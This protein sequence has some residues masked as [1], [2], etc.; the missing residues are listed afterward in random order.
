MQAITKVFSDI[1]KPYIDATDNGL[2]DNDFTN[3][4]VNLLPLITYTNRQFGDATNGYITV[5]SN[6]DGSFTLNGSR[7]STASVLLIPIIKDG[8]Y[9][10]TNN[11]LKKGKS[12]KYSCCPP[13]SVS[14]HL[15]SQI[16]Y[17][18]GS[19]NLVQ[20]EEG[21][22]G[23]T[24]NIPIDATAGNCNIAVYHDADFTDVIISKIQ[25]FLCFT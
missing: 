2:I 3:G 23:V 20:F 15:L 4:A 13:N 11:I 12:Y 17:R 9:L 5:N 19:N 16:N 14:Q 22:A 25:I 21:G 1:V 18:D 8:K 7:I 6:A 10:L 24:I